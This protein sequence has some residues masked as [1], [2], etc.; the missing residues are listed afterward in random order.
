MHLIA[1]KYE[2]MKLLF[3]ENPLNHTI[4]DKFEEINNLCQTEIATLNKCPES[5]KGTVGDYMAAVYWLCNNY[6]FKYHKK[7]A[8]EIMPLLKVTQYKFMSRLAETRN[9]YSH[10]LKESQKPL[11]IAKIQSC[12]V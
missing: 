7:Y 11:R 8:C 6:F 1:T 12:T 3:S 4:T 2:E 5:N 9:W 10:F